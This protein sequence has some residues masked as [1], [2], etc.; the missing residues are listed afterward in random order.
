DLDQVAEWFVASMQGMG[1]APEEVRRRSRHMVGGQIAGGRLLIWELPDGTAVGAA[2]WG[3]RVA[4][5][6]RPS[7]IFISPD[8]RDGGYAKHIFAEVLTGVLENGAD[9]C[10]A[11]VAVKNEAMVAVVRKAGFRPLS[12]IIEYTFE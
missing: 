2:G 5:V 1:L 9:A 10:V 7:G 8:H 12:D 4:G 6:V 11:T 3:P